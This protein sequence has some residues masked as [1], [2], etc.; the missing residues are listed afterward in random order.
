M[1]VHK[2]GGENV[3]ALCLH[4]CALASSIRHRELDLLQRVMNYHLDSM[5]QI[6][7][8]RGP[9]FELPPAPSYTMIGEV[10]LNNIHIQDSKVGLLNTGTMQSIASIDIS[11]DGLR[12]AG[13]LDAA[14]GIRQLAEALVAAEGLDENERSLR[15]DELSVLT[16]QSLVPAGQRKSALVNRVLTDWSTWVSGVAALSDLWARVAPAIQKLFSQ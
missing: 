9:R 2:A 5:T 3:I 6:S 7:G 1:Y 10:M 15:L 4:C 16:E 13:S 8:V 14:E 12:S 11:I